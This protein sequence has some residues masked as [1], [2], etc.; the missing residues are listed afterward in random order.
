[1]VY[2]AVSAL[3]LN[4]VYCF[5]LPRSSPPP[6]PPLPLPPPPS[7]PPLQLLP[8]CQ[9]WYDFVW[10]YFKVM[11]D[12]LTEQVLANKL[13]LVTDLDWLIQTTVVIIMI[14]V[15]R[16]PSLVP[17]PPPAFLKVPRFMQSN[18]AGDRP[19]D[20]ATDC[21]HTSRQQQTVLL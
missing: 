9:S 7:P 8:A 6:S 20:E 18:K 15:V 19:G 17:R 4:Y 1:M 21:P 13:P 12:V 2:F 11:V 3:V 16:I 10:A 14:V 5:S